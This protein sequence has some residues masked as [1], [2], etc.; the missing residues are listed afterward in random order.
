MKITDIANM[1]ED[2]V[3]ITPSGY[4]VAWKGSLLNYVDGGIYELDR[5]DITGT[6]R[7]ESEP[8]EKTVTLTK[9]E[10]LDR[11]GLYIYSH[12][13]NEEVLK[14]LGFEP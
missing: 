13:S 11:V 4:P 1:Q 8:K 7:L 5:K 14:A 9:D 6:W 10:F 3:M 2:I 12:V